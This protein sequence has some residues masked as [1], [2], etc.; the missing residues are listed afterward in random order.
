MLELSGG[1][2]VGT[3]RDNLRDRVH[4][5]WSLANCVI[6]VLEDIF[7]ATFSSCQHAFIV[8][9]DG[10]NVHASWP[11]RL[12]GVH[13]CILFAQQTFLFFNGINA[14]GPLVVEGLKRF[15]ETIGRAASEDDVGASSVGDVGVQVLLD[16]LQDEAL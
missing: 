5:V 2:G 13:V 16:H 4:H 1:E 12:N 14:L 11:S 6:P 15:G 10:Y 9:L 3:C 8:D 7:K